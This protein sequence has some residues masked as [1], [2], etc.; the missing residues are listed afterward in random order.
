MFSY[1]NLPSTVMRHPVHSQIR[2]AYLFYYFVSEE[3]SNEI[4]RYTSLMQDALIA[5]KQVSHMPCTQINTEP[6]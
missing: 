5:A 1:Y 4:D 3:A 6:D 2:A